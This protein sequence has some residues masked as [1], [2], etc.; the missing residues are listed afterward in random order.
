MVLCAL[1]CFKRLDVTLSVLI[2]HTHVHTHIN[3]Q[4]KITGGD[5]YV[6][7]LACGDDIMDTCTCPKSSLSIY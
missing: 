6:L 5:G 7:I 4:N 2:K 1:K 3:A